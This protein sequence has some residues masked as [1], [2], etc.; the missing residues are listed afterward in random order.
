[1]KSTRPFILLLIVT[2]TSFA[3]L[4]EKIYKTVDESGAVV[5]SDKKTE[6]AEKIKVKPNVVNVHVP[7][8]P[9]STP[10]EKPKKTS[11]KEQESQDNEET[12]RGT[13]TAGN[14]RRKIQNV[15]N[16]EGI[17]RPVNLPAKRPSTLPA[18]GGGAR[19][20]GG[21]R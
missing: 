7:K 6:G 2:T 9:E 10:Q 15:T 17:K 3:V 16:G 21:G 13:A 12:G 19:R 14:L 20:A 1:M 8:M 18:Q 5:F 4:A 11:K